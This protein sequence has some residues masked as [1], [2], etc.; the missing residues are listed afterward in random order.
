MDGVRLHYVERGHGDPLVLLHGNTTMGLDFLLG[1]FVRLL[2]SRYRVIIFDRPG[3]GW[4]ERPRGRAV[5]VPRTQAR[6]IHGA[7][8]RIG[9]HR[10]IVH[11]HSWGAMV[12]LAMALDFPDSIRAIV[13]ESGYY[14]PTI[15]GDVPMASQPAM[16]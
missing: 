11:G 2:A 3:C 15:R 8:E 4:S 10:P 1:D 5:Y 13:L 6:L 16:P 9:V 14:Y 12:A 7:L